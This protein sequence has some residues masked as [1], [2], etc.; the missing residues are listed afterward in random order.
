MVSF[1]LSGGLGGD[2]GIIGCL[3]TGTLYL[4]CLGGGLLP[5][6]GMAVSGALV[7]WVV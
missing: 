6:G 5:K 2:G 1:G 3:H 4:D 7:Y